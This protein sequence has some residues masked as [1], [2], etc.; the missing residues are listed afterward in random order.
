MLHL[1]QDVVN[2][3][4][5]LKAKVETAATAAK[6]AVTNVITWTEDEIKA[7]EADLFKAVEAGSLT[8]SQAFAEG[9]KWA[10][11]RV[12][13]ATAE[14]APVV[15]A[16]VPAPAPTPAPVVAP[17]PVAAPV[18]AATMAPVAPVATPAFAVP[19]EVAAAVVS[20]PVAAAVAPAPTTPA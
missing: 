12:Q 8:L 6:T 4:D 16:P 19:A 20:A 13:S 18:V 3:F 7:G 1:F 14:P 9:A 15:A 2:E 10:A 17:A 11:A 5:A